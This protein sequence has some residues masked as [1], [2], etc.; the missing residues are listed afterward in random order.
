MKRLISLALAAA[1]LAL[2]SCT[3]SGAAEMTA[4]ERAELYTTAI[5]GARSQ[6]E[7]EAM[8]VLTNT[9]GE[10]RELIFQVLGLAEEDM[11]AYAISVS[12]VNIRA[13]GIA[14]ILPAQGREEAVKEGL[15]AFIDTQK[16]NFEFYLADQYEVAENARLETLSDG[17]VLMVM[18]QDQDTVYDAVSQGI[19]G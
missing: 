11:E 7:N 17:T 9:Q 8:S 15:Q 1:V 3:K 14:A 16:M 13:Y 5:T 19:E 4:Q 12:L 18:C 10:D 6:E 2:S